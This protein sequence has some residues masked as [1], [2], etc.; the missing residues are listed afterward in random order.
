MDGRKFIDGV[1]IKLIPIAPILE[2]AIQK[3][4][5]DIGTT[6]EHMTPDE[7]EKFIK[8]LTDALTL[9]LGKEGAEK[10]RTDMMKEFRKSAPDHFDE[11]SLI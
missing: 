7:A 8:K 1:K 2:H 10:A 4:L 5:N 11:R 3:Q 6:P 9:F